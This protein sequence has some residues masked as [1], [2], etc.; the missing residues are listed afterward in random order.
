MKKDFEINFMELATDKDS[1][2]NGKIKFHEIT[3]D[4]FNLASDGIL[5]IFDLVEQMPNISFALKV[6]KKPLNMNISSLK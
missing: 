6:T 2:E 3:G 1:L 5:S 4:H